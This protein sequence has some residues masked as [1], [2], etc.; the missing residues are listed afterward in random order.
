MADN[1]SLKAINIQHGLSFSQ[2][3]LF[4]LL[5]DYTFLLPVRNKMAEAKAKEAP[6]RKTGKSNVAIFWV[7][8]PV[9]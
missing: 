9:P 2:A 6:K 5:Q 8:A 1:T 7:I 3:I 4:A